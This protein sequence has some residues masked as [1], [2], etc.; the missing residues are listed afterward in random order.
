MCQIRALNRNKKFLEICRNIFLLVLQTNVRI[1]FPEWPPGFFTRRDRRLFYLFRS[2]VNIYGEV[3]MRE[4][5]VE[6]KI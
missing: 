5:N 6:N 4:L 3:T 1:V 2:L